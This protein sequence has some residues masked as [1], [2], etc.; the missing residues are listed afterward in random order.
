MP[1]VRLTPE[2]AEAANVLL[3]L[4]QDQLKELS[5]EDELCAKFGDGPFGQAATLG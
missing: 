4:V 2:Q 1:G 5:G 3:K